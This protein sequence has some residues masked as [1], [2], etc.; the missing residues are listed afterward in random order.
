VEW[1]PRYNIAPAQRRRVVVEV[2]HSRE[3]H[4]LLIHT[5]VAPRKKCETGGE[6]TVNP[7][8]PVLSA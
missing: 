3:G 8:Q 2:F 1:T 7:A 5:A 6:I 4:P